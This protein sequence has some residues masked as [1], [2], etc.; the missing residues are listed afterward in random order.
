MAMGEKGD[1]SQAS[2][3]LGDR[4]VR[5][6]GDP[7]APAA[8]SGSTSGWGLSDVTG[9]VQDR[10]TDTAGEAVAGLHGNDDDNDK[11]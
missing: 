5:Q 10:V 4:L 3:G 11:G 6:G 8:A 7:A 9:A 1:T 2:G